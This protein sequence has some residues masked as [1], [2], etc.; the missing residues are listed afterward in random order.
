MPSAFEN[1]I[2]AELPLRPALIK[3]TDA[4]GDPRLSALPQVNLAPIGTLYLQDDVS[5]KVTWQKQ[6]SAASN[7]VVIS[8]SFGKVQVRRGFVITAAFT[9]N[10]PI[11]VSTGAGDIAGTSSTSGDTITI[12]NNYLDN[13]QIK[14]L[15]N[16]VQLEKG[17]QVIYSL[18][19]FNINI[20]L[21][22]LDRIIVYSEQEI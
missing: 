5:P 10:E 21:D 12:P 16:G 18:G 4:N 20:P 11:S 1:F 13:H 15:L 2:Y 8:G 17:V 14:F 7:W 3:G 19:K 9:A 6:G 22:P